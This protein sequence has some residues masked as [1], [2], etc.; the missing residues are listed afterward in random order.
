[1]TVL[2]V[3]DR[4]FCQIGKLA[5][6]RGRETPLYFKVGLID[7]SPMCQLISGRDSSRHKK[8]RHKD[9]LFVLNFSLIRSG[10]GEETPSLFQ[11]RSHT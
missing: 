2:T 1:M 4:Q 11:T 8:A 10:T 9:R 7:K 5:K 3:I 6:G